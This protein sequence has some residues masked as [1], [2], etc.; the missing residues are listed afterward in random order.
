[1]DK[2]KK[3]EDGQTH[4]KSAAAARY[5][6]GKAQYAYRAGMSRWQN[7]GQGGSIRPAS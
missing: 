7:R 2:G 3:G 1:L 5:V 6:G 4:R